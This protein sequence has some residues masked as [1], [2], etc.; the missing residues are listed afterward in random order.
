MGAYTGQ[1]GIDE[2]ILNLVAVQG[3][4]SCSRLSLL[5]MF[6]VLSVEIKVVKTKKIG[7][8]VD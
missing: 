2:A 5:G 4:S 6:F 1:A 7:G 3:L 8:R